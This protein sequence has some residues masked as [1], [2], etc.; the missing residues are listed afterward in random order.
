MQKSDSLTDRMRVTGKNIKQ[1]FAPVEE[2][3]HG[4]RTNSIPWD[5]CSASSVFAAE[6]PYMIVS[7]KVL[8]F[9]W[10]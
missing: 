4:I 3:Y 6:A 9:S 10:L 1:L 2:L 8:R 5:I 7:G